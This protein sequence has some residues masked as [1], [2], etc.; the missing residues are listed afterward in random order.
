[1]KN[2]DGMSTKVVNI[3]EY[4]SKEVSLLTQA[5]LTEILIIFAIFTAM[6]KK[7]F[8][9]FYAIVSLIMFNMAYNN[10]KFY[11]KKNMTAIYIILGLFVAITTIV[12]YVF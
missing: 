10:N 3:K 6:S 12:E 8:P 2:K 5:V 1:M 4:S 11:K 9:A 7:F